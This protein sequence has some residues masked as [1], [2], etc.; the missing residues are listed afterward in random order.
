MIAHKRPCE[1]AV[2]MISIQA[3]EL[4]LADLLDWLAADF[5]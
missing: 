5:S 2:K 3:F 1:I 4:D